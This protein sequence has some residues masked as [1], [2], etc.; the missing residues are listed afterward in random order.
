[1]SKESP[2]KT[3]LFCTAYCDTKDTWVSRYQKWINYYSQL[4][5]CDQMLIIDDGS[6]LFPNLHDI[7][8]INQLESSQ[9]ESKVVLFHFPDRLGRASLK[10]FPGWYRSYKFALDYAKRFH[11]EKVI[12][13]ESDFYIL[14]SSLT[15]LINE[16]KTG[17]STVFSSHYNFPECAL[18][19]I[20]SDQFHAMEKFIAHKYEEYVGFDME[21]L[22]PFSHIYR[23]FKG[24]RS[25][26]IPKEQ[27]LLGDYLA[28]APN[29]FSP[30]YS[31]KSPEQ[32]SQTVNN[33]T[34]PDESLIS[35]VGQMDTALLTDQDINAAFKIF[36][37][38]P[39]NINDSVEQ[40]VGSNPDKLLSDFFEMPEFVE[41]P[42]I[43]KL[44]I[45]LAKRIQDRS[46]QSKY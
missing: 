41:R 8:L 35:K 22:I 17:W 38:R 37:N 25:N 19:V 11:F 5:Q 9:P 2:P 34:L 24:D 7:Q 43:K 10:N 12:H 14:T 36:L 45:L 32:N 26:T 27:W 18:Q 23:E 20:C 15:K 3:L 4:I 33:Q 13:I 29:D 39:E 42:G 30:V 28:Q 46:I 1:M 6:A 16:S 44:I 40:W 21:N 31:L